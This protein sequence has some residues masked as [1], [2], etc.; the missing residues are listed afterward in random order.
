MCVYIY[1]FYIYI[2]ISL[3]ALMLIG[4]GKMAYKQIEYRK[5]HPRS[6]RIANVIF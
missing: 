5:T 3:E 1:V 2:H 4:N 6:K